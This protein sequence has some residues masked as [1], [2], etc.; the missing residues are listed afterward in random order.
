MNLA[1]LGSIAGGIGTG[2]DQ[3]ARR[4]LEEI[5]AQTAKTQQGGQEL[6]GSALSQFYGGAP[7]Q[8]SAV[9]G[10]VPIL[11]KL[12]S[13]FGGGGQQ[14]A[15]S[16]P[17]SP[18]A[19]VPPPSP[20]AAP[21]A[22]AAP[23]AAQSPQPGQVP[24]QIAAQ[25]KQLDFPTL[26]Q[27]ISKSPGATPAKI[28]AAL[29][30]L[31]PMMNA[32]A[33][34]QWRQVQTQ[35]A[36]LRAQT[37]QQDVQSKIQDR[38]VRQEQGAERIDISKGREDRFAGQFKEN[39]DVARDKLKLAQSSSDARIR[40]AAISDAEREVQRAHGLIQNEGLYGA[41][42]P[43]KDA[44]LK[45]YQSQLDV[46]KAAVE[47]A[48]GKAAGGARL[49]TSQEPASAGKPVAVTTPEEAMKLK[50]GTL[51]TTPDGKTYTR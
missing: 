21:P 48:K 49:E 32:Q 34:Q 36:P 30:K 31:E 12:K 41:A 9:P 28:G 15:P 40:Q 23:P 44:K 19:A 24:P 26:V 43:D 18:A 7:T 33:L 37:Q 17:P 1:G 22:P 11:D 5:Q 29:E 38:G 46:A 47:E 25:V 45:E 50:P 2:L 42:D 13:L 6:L 51:Y 8:Q 27:L 14:Q 4:R 16:P 35:L 39:M 3:A 20:Q 10:A